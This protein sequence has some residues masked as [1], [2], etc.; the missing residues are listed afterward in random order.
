MSIILEII[1][2]ATKNEIDNM[3]STISFSSNF[4]GNVWTP[5]CDRLAKYGE[6]MNTRIKSA[7][8]LE[9]A[10]VK[11]FILF[12]PNLPSTTNLKP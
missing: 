8:I 9:T 11:A 3:I 5:V 12:I 6:L 4:S 7:D 10:F 1:P 2:N